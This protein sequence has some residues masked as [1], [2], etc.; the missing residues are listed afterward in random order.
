VRLEAG[1]QPLDR[2][3]RHPNRLFPHPSA[4]KPA[5]PRSAF[6]A[7]PR[8]ISYLRRASLE[9]GEG[10]RVASYSNIALMYGPLWDFAQPTISEPIGRKQFSD[11]TEGVYRI[12]KQYGAFYEYNSPTYYGVDL[13]G[14]HFGGTTDRPNDCVRLAARWSRSFGRTKLLSISLDCAMS[15]GPY[16]A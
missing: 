3:N 16:S 15:R 7:P 13:Y 11:W 4:E 12:F 6:A 14:W 8:P 10:E 9:H 5:A 2:R 1:K